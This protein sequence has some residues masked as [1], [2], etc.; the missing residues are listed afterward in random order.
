LIT[1][2]DLGSMNLIKQKTM[3]KLVKMTEKIT[4]KEYLEKRKN[5]DRL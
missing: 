3:H 1:D 2:T 5:N 4:L